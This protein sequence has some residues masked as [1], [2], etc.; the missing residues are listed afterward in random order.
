MINAFK[1]ELRK[2][3]SLRSTYYIL[4]ASFA[5]ELLFAFYAT[6]WRSTPEDLSNPNFLASQAVSAVSLLMFFAS[7]VGILLVTHEYRYNT[8]NYSLTA[9]RSRLKV[10]VAK[11]LVASLFAIVFCFVFGLLS[12]LLSILATELRNLHLAPQNIDFWWGVAWRALFA[13]WGFSMLGFILALIIRSQVGALIAIF[14]MPGP[15]EA[16]LGLLLKKN[17]I[18][19]PFTANSMLLG[20]REDMLAM[21]Y[22]KAAMVVGIYVIVGWLV[23]WVLF[24]RR[25][26]N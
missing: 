21:S 6:G 25:D 18:Y 14:I 17:Q 22:G 5:L 3:F 1:A 11:T 7:L 24:L 23:A 12:P 2:V 4:A 8:I 10:F 16:I 13:G 9:S 15:V 26:A 19:L 20:V